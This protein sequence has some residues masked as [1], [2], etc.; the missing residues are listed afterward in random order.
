MFSHLSM[1]SA[2]SSS[3]GVQATVTLYDFFD[4]GLQYAYLFHGHDYT[5]YDDSVTMRVTFFLDF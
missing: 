2:S 4:L 5:H 1:G 3:T